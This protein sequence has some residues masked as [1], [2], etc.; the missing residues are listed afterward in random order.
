M[1]L[2]HKLW[3]LME[4]FCHE[5]CISGHAHFFFPFIVVYTYLKCYTTSDFH[6][7]MCALCEKG[8]IEG[9]NGPRKE[10]WITFLLVFFYIFSFGQKNTLILVLTIWLSWLHH[11]IIRLHQPYVINPFVLLQVCFKWHPIHLSK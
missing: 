3:F 2:S 1:F 9:M 5:F 7:N 11:I 10:K 4:H 6:L 8:T